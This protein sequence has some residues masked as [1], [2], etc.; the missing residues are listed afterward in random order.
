[1]MTAYHRF[2]HWILIAAGRV[3]MVRQGS[4]HRRLIHRFLTDMIAVGLVTTERLPCLASLVQSLLNPRI[5]TWIRQG[6][7]EQV[8][9]RETG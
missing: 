3:T 8:L 1:M 2:C 5:M 6:I 7:M 9:C 4:S